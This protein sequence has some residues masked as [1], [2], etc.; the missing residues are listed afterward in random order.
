MLYSALAVD[1]KNPAGLQRQLRNAD[2]RLNRLYETV[3]SGMLALGETLQRRVGGLLKRARL[4]S[5][6]SPAC[7]TERQSEHAGVS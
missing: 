6:R 1:G 4:S 5:L 3:D 2:D 7:G